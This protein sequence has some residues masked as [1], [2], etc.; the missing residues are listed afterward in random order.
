MDKQRMWKCNQYKPIPKVTDSEIQ[1]SL[2]FIS[3][4]TDKR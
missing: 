4:I 3:F 2:T 1:I